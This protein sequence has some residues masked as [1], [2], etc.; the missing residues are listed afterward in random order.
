MIEENHTSERPDSVVETATVAPL[1]RVSIQAFCE[2]PDVAQVVQQASGDRRMERAHVKIQMGGPSAAIEAYR[3]AP[4]PNVIIVE[5]D[6]PRDDVIAALDRLA[7]VCDSG[8]KVILIGR[9]NDVLLYREL[10]KRGVSEYLVTPLKPLDIVRSL[11]EL[12]RGPD[13]EPVGRT[14]AFVGAKGG[15]G[16]STMCHNVAWS[17]ARN[18]EMDT[19]VSDLDLAFGTAGLNFNQDPPQGIAEVV[20]SPERVDANMVDRLVYKCT[21]RLSLMAAPATL[22][23]TYDFN[24]DVFDPLL[25]VLRAN[26]PSVV[27]DVPHV[28]TAWSRR[29]MV[30]ADEIVIT[31]VPDLANLRNTKN[32]VDLLRG[33]RPNDKPPRL[34]INQMGMPKRPEIKVADFVKAVDIEPVAAV[35]F[36]P[37]LFGAA[38]NNGQMIAEMDPNSKVNEFFVEVAKTVTGRSEVRVQKRTLLEPL[39]TRLSLKR[40]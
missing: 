35:P 16:S 39:L 4:T 21:E 28:W 33:M 29:L 22:D 2:T 6:R 8:T 18:L 7:E 25:D 5:T 30:L 13:A 27:L 24:S 34:I 38:A 19:V 9:V 15:V 31:A 10:M 11:S 12:F 26:M 20:F 1:P 37:A 17:I 32:F 23:R 40:A 14:I 36:E 3:N